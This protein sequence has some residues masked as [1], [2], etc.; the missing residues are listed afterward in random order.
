[1]PPFFRQKQGDVYRVAGKPIQPCPPTPLKVPGI[2]AADALDANDAEGTKFIIDVPRSG[3]IYGAKMID[4]DKESIETHLFMFSGNI[5]GTA[6]DAAFAPSDTEM[7][8]TFVG[9]WDFTTWETADTQA[10]SAGNLTAP[11]GPIAYV[12]P[13]EKLWCQLVTRGTPT[14]AAGKDPYIQLL[15]I[16]D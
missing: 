8:L 2:V 1:M 15:I 14:I 5:V 13:S 10:V 3:I 16:P 9:L 7:T 6:N 4:P 12:A 11:S